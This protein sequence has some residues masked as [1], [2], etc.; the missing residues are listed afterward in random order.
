[1]KHVLLVQLYSEL[2]PANVEPF[3]IEVL[4]G[5]LEKQ[6]P[7][8]KVNLAVINPLAKGKGINEFTGELA[9]SPY[10]IIGFS[11]PQGTIQT[12][13]QVLNAVEDYYQRKVR[14]IILLGHSLPTNTP[15]T[16]LSKY[17]WA[18]IVHGWGESA[19]K[20][21]VESAQPVDFQNIPGIYYTGDHK[22]NI[23][24]SPEMIIPV[25]P[26]R[27]DSRYY[28]NRVETSRGCSYNRCT[29][30]LRPNIHTAKAKW[31]RIPSQQVF[32]TIKNLKQQGITE[33]TFADED[34]FGNDYGFV[35]ELALGIQKIGGMKFSLS[36]MIDNFF[37]DEATC[38]ENERRLQM[39]KMLHEAGLTLVYCGLESL[40]HSQLKRYGKRLKDVNAMTN[41]VN[42]AKQTQIKL[43]MGFI[44][45]DP[46]VTLMELRENLDMLNRSGFWQDIKSLFSFLNVYKN[47]PYEHWLRNAHL[48]SNFNPDMLLYEWDYLHPDVASIARK[49]QR[50]RNKYQNV[51]AA[52]RHVERTSLSSN[53]AH[54]FLVC[55][56]GHDIQFLEKLIN[57]EKNISS[58][59]TSAELKQIE[60]VRMFSINKLY[61]YLSN[62]DRKSPDLL[63]IKAL[64]DF[65]L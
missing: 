49:C 18:I 1:M 36:A 4:A 44:L 9:A 24:K 28:F 21:I 14:P 19:L 60:A 43:E 63:L 3:A 31:T 41:A 2:Q 17:P 45:F 27:L 50:W 51:Y 25:S 34:F 56:R 57:N 55:F 7:S 10:D 54:E 38:Q 11:I 23:N 53:Y 16:F 30:C 12:A 64:K 22:I 59:E 20:A 58:E 26:E 6:I 13:F 8:C 29:Y 42:T 33:F 15:D 46:F 35:E 5:F 39:W 65:A 40:S 52:L 47:T 62:S 61:T 32:D 37:S 48:L